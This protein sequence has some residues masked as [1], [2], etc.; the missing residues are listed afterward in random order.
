MRDT[1]N[2]YNTTNVYKI[3]MRQRYMCLVYCIIVIQGWQTNAHNTKK[4]FALKLN[5]TS[6]NKVRHQIV[7]TA[8]H[9]RPAI[10]K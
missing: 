5:P 8:K 7:M 2:L 3:E 9:L 10:T 1:L 6:H 4:N